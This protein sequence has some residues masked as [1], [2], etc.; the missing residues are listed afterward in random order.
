MREFQVWNAWEPSCDGGVLQV[1]RHGALLR[2]RVSDILLSG[3]RLGNTAAGC[4][5]G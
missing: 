3:G 4:L 1:E 5:D 2:V